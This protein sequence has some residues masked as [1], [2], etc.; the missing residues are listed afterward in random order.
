MPEPLAYFL[1]WTTYGTWLPGDE[2]GWVKRGKGFQLP[3]PVVRADAEALMTESV[4]VLD[5]AQRDIVEQTIRRHCEIRGWELHAVKAR[6]NHVHVV[7]SA[8][9]KP[10]VIRDQL[11]AWCTRKL[12]EHAA[13]LAREG[14]L[15]RSASKGV[16]NKPNN[17]ATTDPIRTKWWTEKGSIRRIA[18]EESLDAVVIYV[19]EG[20]DRKGRDEQTSNPPTQ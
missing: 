18:D 11:K 13:T 4:C 14:T 1:T 2:R 20:Q 6:S 8:N 15:A 16:T 5:E 10:K 12:K 19:L 7:V 3:D 17:N 9:V